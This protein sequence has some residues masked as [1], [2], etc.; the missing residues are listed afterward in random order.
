VA[1]GNYQNQIWNYFKNQ[2]FSDAGIAGIMGN[3]EAESSYLPNNLE[4]AANTK[5]GMSDAEF[6]TAVDN[7]TISRS[8]FISSTK[9]GVYSNGTY[10]YGLAQWTYSTRKA[11]LY[12]LAKSRGV[13]IA[14]LQMQLDYMMQ[15]IATYSGLKS[16]LC[17]ATDVSEACVKFHNVYEGSA[18]TASKIAGRVTKAEAVYSKYHVST[19]VTTNSSTYSTVRYGSRGSTVKTL[20]TMLNKV[21][22]AGLTVDGI[23]GA[24]TRTAVRNYQSKKG[25]SVDG[26]AGPKT[27]AALEA[28]YK[29]ASYI[30]FSGKYIIK[31]AVKSGM[32]LDVNNNSKSNGANIQI[33]V[34][35]GTAAQTFTVTHVQNGWHK[36]TNSASGKAIDVKGGSSKSGTNVQ[37]YQYNG[38]A[39]Q[40]WKFVSAG[41]GQ[42]YIQ[43][44]LGCFL[45][46]SGGNSTNGTN[47]QVYTGNGTNAQKWSLVSSTR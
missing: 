43:N 19:T 47:V 31:S 33:W 42:Y 2:G 46:V 10:G 35:N 16:Y 45:D 17:N 37:L 24:S 5:S 14:N 41:N 7:G 6:T 32:V 44:K 23:F 18:D 25:L 9:F 36:I 21:N 3:L 39:A 20:Q 13:S 38:T 40:L 11:G 1:T 26:I 30:I 22:N 27:W 28:D 12:D 34:A 4:N 29:N 8:E 15:E